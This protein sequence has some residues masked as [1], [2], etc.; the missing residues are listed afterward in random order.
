VQIRLRHGAAAGANPLFA[1][2]RQQIMTKR[3]TRL[4]R[5]WVSQ[6]RAQTGGT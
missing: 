2:I 6:R 5:A 4:Y 3:R 1:L